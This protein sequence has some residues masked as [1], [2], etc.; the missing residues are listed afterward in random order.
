MR[1]IPSVEGEELRRIDSVI[2]MALLFSGLF[3]FTSTVQPVKAQGTIYIMP[4]GSI[5]PSTANITTSDEVTYTFTGNNSVPIVVLR[6][7]IIIDGRGYTLQVSANE[8]GF[9]LWSMNNVTIKNTTITNSYY[10]IDL[11]SSSGNVL[12]GNNVTAN[13]Y[14]IFLYISSNNTISGNN[15]TANSA[16]GIFLYSSSNNTISGNNVNNATNG[17]GIELGWS[18]SNNTVSGNNITANNRM[19]IYLFTYCDGNTLSGNNVIANG[20]NNSAYLGGICLDIFSSNNTIIGNEVTAN[21][22]G[23]IKLYGSSSNNTVSGNHVTGSADGIELWQASDNTV[24]R[25]N[26]TANGHNGIILYSASNNKIIGNNAT[27]TTVEDGIFLSTHSDGNTLSDNNFTGNKKRGIVLDWSSNNNITSN[28]IADN[29]IGLQL[30]NGSLN[31]VIYHN[32]FTEN[33]VQA[34]TDSASTGNAWNDTYPSGGNYWSDYT[35][36]DEKSGPYQN[37]TGSDGIGDTPYIID[38]RNRDNYP[39]MNGY[40]SPGLSVSILP[41]ST[42]LQVGQSQMFTSSVSGGTGPFSYEWYVNGATVPGETASTFNYTASA[43]DVGSVTIYVRVTDSASV[44]VTAQSN[45]ASVT[46]SA[47]PPTEKTFG[48]TTVGTIAD[49]NPVPTLQ[50]QRFQLT[51]NG[52]VSKL[53]IYVGGQSSTC[54]II[55]VIYADNAGVPTTLIA[56]TPPTNVAGTTGWHDLVFSSPISLTAG[57]YHLGWLSGASTTLTTYYDAGGTHTWNT[58]LQSGAPF[59]PTPPNPF[60]VENHNAYTFSIYATYTPPPSTG[61][62]FGKT[63]V[64][65]I[66]DANR[67]PTLQ[68]QRFQLTETGAVSKL[69][70]YVSGQSS[71][72][73]II[74][75][76]YADNAGVPTT[77][78]AKTPIT[79]VAGAAGWYDLVFSSPV[80]LTAGYYHLGWLSG[81]ST[82]LTTYYDAGGTHTWN[83]ALQ[84]GAPFYPTPPNPFKVENHNAYTFSIYATYTR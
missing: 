21:K 45:T 15:A 20:V 81:V 4:D 54:N 65:T 68:V 69:T 80:S 76:I 51:E 57:Y 78:V 30:Q 53:T 39:L 1:F 71:S 32:N 43:S 9:S 40:P 63:T 22:R 10:G 17:H 41:I 35:G 8:T 24:S 27:A 48:K 6:S 29:S 70:V 55:G 64:G 60:K 75:V 49:F 72:C 34:S 56:K 73:N 52:T 44:P 74:G 38:E 31:N 46:V 13:S 16:N 11:G 37:L 33:I 83:T 58:A 23:G 77:L 5:S 28:K 36:V 84:S 12:S 66:A 19:G 18:S 79:N 14:G 59:Y 42:T 67:V 82:T 26:S 7:N 3:V 62:T 25:N 47:P 2:I 61:N 50:V